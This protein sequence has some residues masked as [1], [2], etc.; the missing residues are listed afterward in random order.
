MLSTEAR[1]IRP[2]LGSHVTITK[3]C[4]KARKAGVQT[5]LKAR[6]AQSQGVTSTEERLGQQGA[7]GTG[8]IRPDFEPS[9]PSCFTISF[10][11]TIAL[12]LRPATRSRPGGRLLTYPLG[13]Q[14]HSVADGR[15][16]RQHTTTTQPTRQRLLAF[17]T[18]IST[19]TIMDTHK[20]LR[21]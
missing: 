16:Y 8:R 15:R 17:A 14:K 12:R 18:P 4:S 9:A 6:N 20:S 21:G 1:P 3:T 10:T 2:P 7:G 19:L 13:Q 11:R 5:G